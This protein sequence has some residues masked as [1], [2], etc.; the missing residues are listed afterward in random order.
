MKTPNT[1][2]HNAVITRDERNQLNT[3]KSMVCGELGK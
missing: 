1:I 2:R 3:Y